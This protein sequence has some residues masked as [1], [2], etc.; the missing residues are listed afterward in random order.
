MKT[1][2]LRNLPPDLREVLQ[3]EAAA[4]GS[5]LA[6]TVIRL[7]CSAV[8]LTSGRPPERYGDLDDLAGTWSAAESDDF[9]RHLA[10]ARSIDP[11]LWS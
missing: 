11:E 4:S 1:I 3:R 10:G 2:T 9:D 5:S 8:G 6:A 7:L